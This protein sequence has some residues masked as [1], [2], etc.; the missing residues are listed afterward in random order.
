MMETKNARECVPKVISS[1]EFDLS[2]LL[3][4][5]EWL[6]GRIKSLKKL[7]LFLHNYDQL[8]WTKVSTCEGKDSA[9]R[10]VSSLKSH[11]DEILGAEEE[12]VSRCS[13]AVSEIQGVMSIRQAHLRVP[14]CQILDTVSVLVCPIVFQLFFVWHEHCRV[15]DRLF[16]SLDMASARRSHYSDC[17]YSCSA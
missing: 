8:Q 6:R 14:Q 17:Y 9:K 13:E 7:Q 15:W 2:R 4:T 1:S 3:Y 10:V 11:L 12:L 16:K 5:K